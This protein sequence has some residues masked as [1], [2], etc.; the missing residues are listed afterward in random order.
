LKHEQFH[1][2][3]YKNADRIIVFF[4]SYV[5]L[6]QKCFFHFCKKLKLSENYQV[7]AKFCKNLLVFVK[8]FCFCKSFCTNKK[9]SK[10]FCLRVKGKFFMRKVTTKILHFNV[11]VSACLWLLS[12]FFKTLCWFDH[13]VGYRYL[14]NKTAVSF[15]FKQDPDLLVLI[16]Q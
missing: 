2:F 13:T 12:H 5:R 14:Y 8:S 4:Y 11:N 1:E 15:V 10:S 7:F 3:I 9:F 16:T 6:K